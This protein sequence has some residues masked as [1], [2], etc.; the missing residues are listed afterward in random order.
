MCN[1][2]IRTILLLG[3]KLL[4]HNG[5]KNLSEVKKDIP[6]NT[7]DELYDYFEWFQNKFLRPLQ[8]ACD[9]YFSN[10]FSLKLLAISRNTNVLTQGEDYFV[11]RIKYDKQHDVLLKTSADA[12][13]IILDKLFGKK[14]D[15]NVAEI[16]D[17]EAKI[18]SSF[19]NYLY[20]SLSKVIG[21]SGLNGAN[22]HSGKAKKKNN[23][24]IVHLTFFIKEAD[25]VDSAK[26]ILSFPMD[27]VSPFKNI[28]NQKAFDNSDFKNSKVNVNIEVGTTKFS[29]KELKNLEREDIVVFENS[30]IHSMKLIYGKYK[31]DFKISPNPAL[32]TSS[33][34]GGAE[35]AEENA[36]SQ[37]MW[38]NIQ[39]EMGAEFDKVKITLGELKNIEEGLVVDISSVY[40]NKIS[41]KVENKV[42]AQGELVIINDRYGVKIDKVFAAE[43]DQA[44]NTVDSS[45]TEE[46]SADET[47]N[48]ENG[49]E[50]EFNYDDFNLEEEEDI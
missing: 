37:D 36:L 30:N 2:V 38:D 44:Q 8:T 32:V 43:K 39:V 50:E 35:M 29:L 26:I 1:C 46:D 7:K 10:G 33:N 22:V 47:E 34:N 49:D 21:K 17:L 5:D 16:T 31:K 12:V 28:T 11:T 20:E 3:T 25:A 42:I 15:F 4:K 19:N 41:L 45:I 24:D 18:I 13:K 27:L 40:D 14:P 23:K 9:E 48:S 6:T